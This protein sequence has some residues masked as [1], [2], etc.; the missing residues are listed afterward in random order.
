MDNED[1]DLNKL[2]ILL[3]IYGHSRGVLKNKL[4]YIS[5]YGQWNR[6]LSIVNGVCL[7]LANI[8]EFNYRGRV[9]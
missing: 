2:K 6:N 1:T 9:K 7:R 8:I 5:F 4:S 3:S